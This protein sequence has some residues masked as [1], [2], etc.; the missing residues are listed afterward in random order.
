MSPLSHT[1]VIIA[2]HRDGFLPQEEGGTVSL[3]K[4]GRIRIDYPVGPELSEAM[5]SAHRH[6]AQIHL[7]AGVQT[8]GTLHND[9]IMMQSEQE[10]SRLEAAGYGAL[11]HTIFTAHQMGGC[12]MGADPSTSVVDTTLRHHQVP[13]LYVVDG[14]VFPTSLGVNP[15]QTIYSLAHWAAD[16]VA[17]A[18]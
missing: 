7:A 4:D 6:L 18:V 16:G 13:N 9:P 14:S 2:V 15:S 1:A 17:S 8:V 12:A 10:L 3:R 11:E 5:K